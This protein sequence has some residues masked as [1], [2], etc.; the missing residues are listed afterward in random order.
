MVTFSKSSVSTCF[1][2]EYPVARFFL[3]TE[4]SIFFL[5]KEDLPL[6]F[7]RLCNTSGK[8]HQAISRL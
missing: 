7:I 1:H 3:Q 5:K 6:I 2:I 8:I 4:A